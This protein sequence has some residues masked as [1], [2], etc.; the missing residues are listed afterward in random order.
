MSNQSWG[1][2]RETPCI[3]INQNPDKMPFITRFTDFKSNLS[4]EDPTRKMS[5]LSKDFTDLDPELLPRSNTLS[6]LKQCFLNLE[7]EPREGYGLTDAG[8]HECQ[9]TDA[10]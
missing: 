8:C 2:N 9:M 10:G 5:R 6:Q 1:T 3:L 4:L 7:F